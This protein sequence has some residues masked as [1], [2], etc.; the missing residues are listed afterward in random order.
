MLQNAVLI[1]IVSC[2]SSNIITFKDSDGPFSNWS[3]YRIQTLESS[4][5]LSRINL[6]MEM[7]TYKNL[8]DAGKYEYLEIMDTT[9]SSDPFEY[10]GTYL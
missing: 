4:L 9:T 8:S 1:I 6:I 10:S 5:Q 7:K 2:K 3:I